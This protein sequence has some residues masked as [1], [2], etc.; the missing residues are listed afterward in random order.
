MTQSGMKKKT[1]ETK[2]KKASRSKTASTSSKTP[3][4]SSS[5]PPDKNA[6]PTWE[7][8]GWETEGWS[9]PRRINAKEHAEL[10]KCFDENGKPRI[11]VLGRPKK[12]PDE[13]AN[14]SGI[15]LSLK[16]RRAFDAEAK[17]NGFQSWQT[18]LKDLGDRAAGLKDA[19]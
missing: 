11:R 6:E 12:A 4:A 16:Q 1:A 3:A 7:D 17:R 18:W 13:K 15:R 2:K 19:N 9:K 10:R 8:E 14:P 5:Q